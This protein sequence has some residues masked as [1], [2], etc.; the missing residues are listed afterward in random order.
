MTETTQ[1]ERSVA[2][3][4]LANRDAV[5]RL[6]HDADRL[7]KLEDGIRA[8]AYRFETDEGLTAFMSP[9]DTANE[10]ADRLRA[11]LDGE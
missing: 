4:G 10:C 11:L 1:E 8:L 3:C 5:L 7:A 6:A 2:R 9:D